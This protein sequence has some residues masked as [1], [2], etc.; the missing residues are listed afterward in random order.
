MNLEDLKDIEFCNMGIGE[1][2]RA[3]GITEESGKTVVM[4][5]KEVNDYE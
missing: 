3:I 2:Y 1:Y 4:M 5:E